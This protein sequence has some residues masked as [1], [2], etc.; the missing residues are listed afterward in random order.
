MAKIRFIKSPTGRFKLA[1]SAG[2]EVDLKDKD[3]EDILIKEGYAVYV[4]PVKKAT[5][6]GGK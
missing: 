5:K 6:K 1:Y 4:K 2:N 3:K